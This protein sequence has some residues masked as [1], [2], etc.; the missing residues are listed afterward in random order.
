MAMDEDQKKCRRISAKR[1][2]PKLEH[3]LANSKLNGLDV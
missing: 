3:L 2:F 1:F